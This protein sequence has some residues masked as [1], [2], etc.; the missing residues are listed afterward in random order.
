[1]LLLLAVSVIPFALAR[2]ETGE[3]TQS[4]NPSG[5]VCFGCPSNG[6]HPGP[7]MPSAAVRTV[8][9][10]FT[11]GFYV[12]GGRSVD[13]IGNDFTHPFEFNLTPIPGRSSP[14][15]IPTIR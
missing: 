1:M 7:D 13:G 6:W 12:I 8:G 4:K 11:D 10:L 5:F 3:R 14:L 2:R 9:I 15:H